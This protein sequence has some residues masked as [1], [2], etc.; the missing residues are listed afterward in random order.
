ME[1]R[2]ERAAHLRPCGHGAG[3]VGVHSKDGWLTPQLKAKT[4]DG[5]KSLDYGQKHCAIWSGF[6]KNDGDW[7]CADGK[8]VSFADV[9]RTWRA[10]AACSGIRPSTRR[11]PT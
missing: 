4:P 8:T 1:R 11:S 2:R 7:V 9:Y 10:S 6:G 5:D 3:W